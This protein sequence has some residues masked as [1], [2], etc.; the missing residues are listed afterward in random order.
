MERITALHSPSPVLAVVGQQPAK[1]IQDLDQESLILALDEVKDPGNLGTIIRIADWFGI[2]QVVVSTHSVDLYNPKTVQAT[3]GSLF[4][5]KMIETDLSTLFNQLN[6]D[7][8]VYGAMLEGST[9]YQAELQK[10]G[11]ILMGNESKGIAQE[12]QSFIS[13]PLTIPKFGQAESLNVATATAIICSEF[14]RR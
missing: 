10:R 14:R 4:R 9:I 3:M 13:H 7:I 2:D 8:P 1:T 6:K 12:L 11:V 5:V